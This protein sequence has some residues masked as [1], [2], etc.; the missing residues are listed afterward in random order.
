MPQTTIYVSPRSLGAPD[1]R[2]PAVATT[3]LARLFAGSPALAG[4]SLRVDAG[5]AIALLGPNGAGKTTLLR[6]L[7]TA[8]RPSY[9]RA[10]VDGLDV[11]RDAALVRERVAYLSH[12]TGLYDDLSARE[13]LRFAATMLGTPEP[14]A[15]VERALADVG[16]ATRADDRVRD[17]SAGMRKRLALGRILLGSASL[18]LLD[19]PYAALDGDGMR[20][21]DQLL[22]AWREVGVSVLVASHS[23]ERFESLLDGR[24]MLD[25]GLVLETSGEGVTSEPP[26]PSTATRPSVVG[27]A[28]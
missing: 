4:V 15:R 19:E 24:V 3:D 26:S 18:V 21:V 20:L 14:E 2:P 1:T 10:S 16:L 13:N 7:A 8:I 11:D 6:L 17:F 5:R 23:T 28:R 12:A 25:R 9:G 22:G 27:A